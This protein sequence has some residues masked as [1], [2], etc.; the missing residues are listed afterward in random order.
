MSKYLTDR[1]TYRI[2]AYIV[3]SGHSIAS[4]AKEIGMTRESLSSRINGKVDF[5]R[6][7]MTKIA[8]VLEKK[9][10]EVFL[11]QKLLKMQLAKLNQERKKKNEWIVNIAAIFGKKLP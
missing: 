6:N 7:E 1:E 2:K 5:G 11:S 9:P 8:M 10:E 4:L 3:E